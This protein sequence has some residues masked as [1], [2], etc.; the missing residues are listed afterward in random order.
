MVAS[1]AGEEQNRIGVTVWYHDDNK[2][3]EDGKGSHTFTVLTNK[4]LEEIEDVI[5]QAI[6]EM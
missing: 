5:K 3:T 4:S 6:R 2:K 1:I